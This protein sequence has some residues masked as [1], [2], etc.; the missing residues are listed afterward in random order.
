M[1]VRRFGSNI[2]LLLA[3]IAWTACSSDLIREDFLP[4]KGCT[5][6]VDATKGN[7]TLDTRGL[8]PP[9]NNAINAVWREGDQVVV[10]SSVDHVVLGSMV[11]TS[12]GSNQT[13]LKAT[14]NRTVKKGDQ[15]ILAFPRT[16]RDYTGQKGTLADIAANY[17]Y[18]TATVT[19]NFADGSFVSA[20]DAHFTNLQSIVR[21]TLKKADNSDLPVKNLIIEADGLIQNASP[22]SITITPTDATNDFYAALSGIN[23]AAVTLTATDDKDIYTYTTAGTKT[24]AD[25]K[26]Y[27]IT[28]KMQKKPRAYTEPL[29]FESFDSR[30][31][32]VWAIESGDLEYSKNGGEWKAYK[33]N[34]QISI[35]NGDIIKF[36]GTQATIGNSNSSKYMQIKCNSNCYIYGNIMSLLSKDNFATMT[37]LPYAYTFQNLFQGNTYIYH[38]EG[39]DLVLPATVLKKQCYYNMFNGCTNMNY[40]KCLATDISASNCTNNWLKG[41]PSKTSSIFVKAAGV[42]WPRNDSGIPDKWTI[43]E[44]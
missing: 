38:T 4:D 3:V 21:F 43:E 7:A 40:L 29:T 39:K 22:G 33:S 20:T 1:A 30:K 11:P 10:L 36:R 19:V 8:N 28:A 5:L 42:D 17:D 2:L 23:N 31:G 14:L 37:E 12:Y 9:E 18:A 15:L 35:N 26:F 13:K 24:F 44:E 6:I 32:S 25:G 41:T 34:Q 27:R 16:G